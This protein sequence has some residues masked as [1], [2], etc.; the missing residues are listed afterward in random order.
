MK[1]NKL[2][3]LFAVL[4]LTISP[5]F[6]LAQVGQTVSPL[7][8]WWYY[9]GNVF[10]IRPFS[11]STHVL[12]GATATTT[13][14][15]LETPSLAVTGLPS[16][17]CVGTDSTGLF[18]SGT[19]TGGG[20]GG[21]SYWTKTGT[22]LNTSSTITRVGILTISPSSTLHVIGTLQA[23]GASSLGSTLAV[24]GITN[25][26]GLT[27]NGNATTTSA[28]ITGLTASTAL[29]SDANKTVSSSAVTA[30]ELGYL[31]GVTS[32][33][34]TQINGKQATLTTGNLTATSPVS[35][36]GSRTV[37]GGAADI[38]IQNAAADGSTK[39]A[40]SFGASD[41]DASSGNITIDYTNGQKATST[42]AGFLTA[43]D[44]TAFN[45]K[46]SANQTIT[47]SG[48]VS[49]SG[50][51]GIT[52]T[53]GNDKILEAML[54]SVN[55]P[56][57]EYCLTYESTTGDFEWQTCGA[58]TGITSLNGLTG[59]TQTFASSTTGTDFAIISSGTVHTFYLPTASG[60]ARGLLGSSDWTTFN[61][62]QAGDA[63]LT[64]LAAY[65]TNGILTQTA[66]DTFTGRTITGT[67]NRLTVTNGDG[68]SGNPT[69]DI[70]S[71]YAGQNTI[72]T[73]GTITSGTWNGGVIPV[74]YGGTGT[75]TTPT[76]LKLLTGNGTGYDLLTL[77]AG[78]G[79]TVA[80]STTA[81]T[82]ASTLG[83]SVDLTSE[84]NGLLPV[85]N[86]STS[87]ASTSVTFLFDQ[88]TS[89]VV[90][91]AGSSKQQ[92]VYIPFKSTLSLVNCGEVAS[93]TSTFQI[94]RATA[95]SSYTNAQ[96][97][98]PSIACGVGGNATTTFSSSTIPAGTWLVVNA[99]STAGS[100]VQSQ[101]DVI[102]R[103]T[104]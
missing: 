87:I 19:C 6:A 62:K 8:P 71:S 93:A 51:T 96:D 2:L 18:I 76:A 55:G 40:A 98:V 100:P 91:T 104:D 37:I 45:N 3:V 65:N 13:S 5:A 35:V 78:S 48:D 44:W 49:G 57:D 52:T 73:V 47:L 82:I 27:N 58:G 101:V 95:N 97:Y 20:G 99:T 61:G 42:V 23:T 32:A 34:Q 85:A 72:A 80:T 92:K 94:Y 81:L 59:A 15:F 90:T 10:G 84:V 26:N 74:A 30:T 38:S 29:I 22:F 9:L 79:I 54:K 41:F 89:T 70:S 4:A 56:T 24:T 68:V 39:G 31:S 102:F 66:A 60:S 53:I 7:S 16:E 46:L 12:I 69:L 33:I 14:S 25:L 67:S 50:T 11:T 43:S 63:T 83:T 21:D 103:K 77:T 17:N 64:A 36:S 88:A 28:V 1:T 75:S 86:M